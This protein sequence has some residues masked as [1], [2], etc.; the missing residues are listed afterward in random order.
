M[1]ATTIVAVTALSAGC[2]TGAHTAPVDHGSTAS[3]R[4]PQCHAASLSAT[5]S[6][7]DGSALPSAPTEEGAALIA[8]VFTNEGKHSCVLQGWPS[9]RLSTAGKP[10]G[11]GALRI[12]A[13]PHPAVTLRP[14]HRAQAYIA[15][16]SGADGFGCDAV[17]PDAL[18]VTAPRT[19]GAL[20]VGLPVHYLG[21]MCSSTQ[22]TSVGVEA[23]LP[24]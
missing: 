22:A 4:S 5:V 10:F 9:V 20:G 23:V 12:R 7:R 3:M 16:H 11:P 6:G 8:L 19:E 18:A 17:T 21:A 13:V 14:G 24:L 1:I 15:L 2:S